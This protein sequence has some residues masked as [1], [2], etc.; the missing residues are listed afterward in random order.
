MALDKV[1][2]SAELDANLT[3]VA[4]AIRTKG[5]TSEALSFPDGFVSAVEDIQAGGGGVSEQDIL[6]ALAVRTFPSG[7]IVINSSKIS[8]NAF[9]YSGITSVSCPNL[10]SVDDYAFANCTK[11]ESVSMPEATSLKYGDAMNGVFNG[12]SKLKNVYMPKFTA[13]NSN[14]IKEVFSSCVS[15][16]EISLPSLAYVGWRMFRY[17]SKLKRV[18]LGKATYIHQGFVQDCPECDTV[19]IRTNRL[20]TLAHASECFSGTKI[21]KGTGYIYV[22]SALVDSYKSATNWSN[23]ADQIRAIEDYPEICG[24]VSA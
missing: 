9:R 21:A 6:E 3:A 12:C 22:P 2:D 20:S 17:C 15:L 5:G 4:D 11:L 16:E 19:I 14:D 18:D 7:D 8:S 24:E 23:Y 10:I 13:Y 1:I